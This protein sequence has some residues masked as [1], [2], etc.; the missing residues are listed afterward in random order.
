MGGAF[1]SITFGDNLVEFKDFCAEQDRCR[2]PEERLRTRTCEK[3]VVFNFI[4]L[5]PS[6]ERPRIRDRDTL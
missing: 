2:S 3:R 5:R 4:E 1:R 6:V